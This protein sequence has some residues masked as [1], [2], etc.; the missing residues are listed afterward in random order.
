MSFRLPI[1]PAA[2]TPIKPGDL[3]NILRDIV[4]CLR[5]L[6]V[7]PPPKPDLSDSFIRKTVQFLEVTSLLENGCPDEQEWREYDIPLYSD[8]ASTIDD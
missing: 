4:N 3:H 7:P 8:K 1:I 6:S 2:G 5:A